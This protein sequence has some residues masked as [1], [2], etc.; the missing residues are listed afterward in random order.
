MS[1]TC[2][3][4]GWGSGGKSEPLGI[5]EVRRA[6]VRQQEWVRATQALSKLLGVGGGA[7]PQLRGNCSR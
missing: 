5:W 3:L 1:Y 6:G 2:L 7:C 4:Q